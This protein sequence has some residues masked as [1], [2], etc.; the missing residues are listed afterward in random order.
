ML[1]RVISKHQEIISVLQKGNPE[2]ISE[3]IDRHVPRGGTSELL[4]LMRSII[5]PLWRRMPSLLHCQ[6]P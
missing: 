2:R 3:T 5:L 1:N 4:K 6:F